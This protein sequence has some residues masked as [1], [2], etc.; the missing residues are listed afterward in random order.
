M[1]NRLLLISFLFLIAGCKSKNAVPHDV[2][3]QKKM[4]AVLFDMMRADQFLSDYVLNKDSSLKKDAESIKLYQQVLAVNAVTKEKFVRSFTFYKMHPV[5]LKA[6]MD[7]I[8]SAPEPLVVTKTV[9]K[10]N[11]DSLKAVADS[12]KK[13]DSIGKLKKPRTLKPN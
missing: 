1:I 5:L 9:T 2:L 7:S 11:K 3:P 12:I 8:V 10:P 4:Q 13:T 6:I